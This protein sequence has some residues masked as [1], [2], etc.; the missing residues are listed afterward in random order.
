MWQWF[1]AAILPLDNFREAAQVPP[2]MNQM[3]LACLPHILL[4]LSFS[5]FQI[6]HHSCR[7]QHTA[8]AAHLDVSAPNYGFD[9]RFPISVPQIRYSKP[10]ILRC[11]CLLSPNLS[12]KLEHKHITGSYY[13]RINLHWGAHLSSC[14]FFERLCL[15]SRGAVCT[16]LGLSSPY[17]S[18]TEKGHAYI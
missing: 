7:L 5:L 14:E 2:M 16:F 4:Q 17:S 11:T 13:K 9:H 1:L 8:A 15:G 18:S 3:Q 6:T 12:T 10:L